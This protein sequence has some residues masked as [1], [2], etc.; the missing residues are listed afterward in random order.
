MYMYIVKYII[1]S[2]FLAKSIFVLIGFLQLN[3][4]SMFETVI[5]NIVTIKDKITIHKDSIY[6]ALKPRHLILQADNYINYLV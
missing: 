3:I 5:D 4:F 2:E 6:I 1:Y